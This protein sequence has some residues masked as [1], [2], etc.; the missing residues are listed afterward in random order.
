MPRRVMA[1]AK[2]NVAGA[3]ETRA[4]S[5]SQGDGYLARLVKY[6]PSEIITVYVILWDFIG[7][8]LPGSAKSDGR[9]SLDH[10]QQFLV[11]AGFLVATPIYT[12]IATNKKG[13]SPAM[14][15]ILISI[16]S[17]AAWA[18]ALGGPFT[19]VSID[20]YSYAQNGAVISAVALP[21]VVLVA[22]FIV[23]KPQQV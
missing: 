1:P 17:F 3:G 14:G 4:A 7:M 19:T 11:F 18:F 5:S 10:Q 20:G 16:V 9:L 21:L 13:L 12:F 15:Q 6:I 8:N 23:P 22:G 2:A